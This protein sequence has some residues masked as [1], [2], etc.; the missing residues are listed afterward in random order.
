M[1]PT[2]VR[3]V[4]H[5]TGRVID[6]M[7]GPR[8]D[9]KADSDGETKKMGITRLVN[10][11]AV[12]AKEIG[13]RQNSGSGRTGASSITPGGPEPKARVLGRTTIAVQVPVPGKEKAGR[14]IAVSPIAALPRARG[15]KL[16]TF[17]RETISTLMGSLAST[18]AAFTKKL[19]LHQV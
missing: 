12:R 6:R 16:G 18:K 2:T 7:T 8:G 3:Q 19:V 10:P 13:E 1:T 9:G 14:T 17:L 15:R 5:T 4:K 11:E